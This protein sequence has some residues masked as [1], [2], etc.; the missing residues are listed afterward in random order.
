MFLYIWGCCTVD[1]VLYCMF[2]HRLL[3]QY[4]LHD[5]HPCF[6]VRFSRILGSLVANPGQDSSW[7]VIAH[8]AGVDKG[9]LAAWRLGQSPCGSSSTDV[10]ASGSAL[11]QPLPELIC[12]AAGPLCPSLKLMRGK[13]VLKRTEKLYELGSKIGEGSFGEVFLAKRTVPDSGHPGGFDLAVK[14][15]KSADISEVWVEAYLLDRCRDH[16][17][18]VQLVDIFMSSV[19]VA[20]LN[21]VCGYGGRDLCA[22]LGDGPVSPPRVREVVGHV[23]SGLSH[24][25]GLGLLHGDLKPANILVA[26]LGDSWLCRLA[27]LGGALEARTVVV[28]SVRKWVGEWVG[29]L[30]RLL[31][32]GRVGGRLCGLVGGVSSP[33]D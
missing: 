30:F 33:G 10:S 4:C 19:P 3:V 25:H 13:V 5:P 26:D 18:I 32:G 9:A 31:V 2:Y 7:Q 6:V 27:D 28:T 23:L 12:P 14:R 22:V 29:G 17:H 1:L 8:S 16:P 21:L 15:M 11:V 24:L 20:S